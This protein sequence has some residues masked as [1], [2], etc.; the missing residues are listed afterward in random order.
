MIS[1]SVFMLT[2][3]IIA[4]MANADVV[5]T[6]RMG[7]CRKYSQQAMITLQEMAIFNAYMVHKWPS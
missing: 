2:L 7:N 3:S 1:Q 6:Q 5:H 4:S